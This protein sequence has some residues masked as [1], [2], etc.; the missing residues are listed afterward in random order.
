MQR[1]VST[2]VFG[3]LNLVFAVFG[4][5][6]ILATWAMF[7]SD[8]NL[9]TKSNPVIELM[10]HNE[11]YATFSK[12]SLSLGL[13]ASIVLGLAGLGLLLLKP[14]G[15]YLSIGYSVYA[16]ISVIV[17]LVGNYFFLIQPFMEKV[18]KMPAGPEQ[19]GMIGGI[20]GSVV[21]GCFGFIYSAIL[22]FFMFRPNVVAAFKPPFRAESISDR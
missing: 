7:S 10:Q 6:S 3:I 19:A 17:G 21:G 9:F 15:R 8:P 1:P 11:N 14:W 4:V 18:S 12:I 13:A 20:V 5:I 16:L 22:L 2:I